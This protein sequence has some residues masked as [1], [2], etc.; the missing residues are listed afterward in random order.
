MP[1]T[2]EQFAQMRNATRE[3]IQAAAMQVFVRKGFGSANVQDIAD[4]AGI[5]IGLLYRHYRSKESLFHELLEYALAG[6]GRNIRAFES[7]ASPKTLIKRFVD[8]VY[9][10]MVS[11]DELANLLLLMSQSLFAGE[12]QHAKRDEV[13]L[14]GAKMI[15]A[16]SELIQKGQ[17]LG[18]FR[19]GNSY[20]MAVYFYSAIQGLA[21]MKARLQHSFAMPSP[22][23]LTAFLFK[24]GD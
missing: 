10:D 1:R 7:D 15:Q 6:L 8:E 4:A 3:K 24:E 17:R 23:I 18:E 9:S 20:E 2:K 19:S 12:Q 21:E 5:S 16:T 13:A 11:G 22:S 14:L